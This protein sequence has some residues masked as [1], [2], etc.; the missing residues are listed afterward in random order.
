MSKQFRILVITPFLWSGAGKAIVRLIRE[1][2]SKGFDFEL[3]SSGRSRGQKDW[4]EYV[5]ELHEME[6]PCHTI[7][8]FDRT[9]EVLWESINQLT[10]FI[11]SREIHL[12]HVHAGVPAFAAIVARDRLGARFPIAA[13][14]HS[15]NPARPVWMNHADIWAL[16]R[17]DRVITDSHSYQELL[18][19]WGL[20]AKRSETIRLGIDIPEPFFADE[21]KNKNT[22]KILAVG[23]IEP[24]KDQVTLLH[25]FSLFRNKFPKASLT[26]A[27]PVGDEAYAQ[28]MHQ[29]AVRRGWDGGVKYLGK[30]RNLPALYHKSDV[31]ISTSRD[32]GLGLAV[33]EAMSHGLPVIC[34]PVT[35]HNDFVEDGFNARL[36]P[37]G[38]HRR[39]AMA[40]QEFHDN[41]EMCACLGQ[42]A[43]NM[44]A[45]KFSWKTAADRYAGVFRRVFASIQTPD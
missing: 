35:G 34:T 31:F 26:L 2:K 33:L 39:L 6:I 3:I 11:R 10:G 20:N 16:N 21:D 17:C 1:L 5:R 4:P 42:N 37:V 32:E 8:F 45:S 23:R 27:G 25:G 44:V 9:P 38:D 28:R 14:F 43:R 40:I 19:A 15:W 36:M 18:L 13:T 30:V 41:P 12:V 22:F 29:E 7:D 24:R